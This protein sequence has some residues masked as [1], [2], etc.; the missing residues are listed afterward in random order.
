MWK[1]EERK[2]MPYYLEMLLFVVG[3]QEIVSDI[4][5]STNIEIRTRRS[6]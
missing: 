6:T 3:P 5:K 1:D 4:K 2:T